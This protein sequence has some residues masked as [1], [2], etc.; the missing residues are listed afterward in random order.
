MK[1]NAS[2]T[3]GEVAEVATLRELREPELW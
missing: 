3:G 1:G 2:V